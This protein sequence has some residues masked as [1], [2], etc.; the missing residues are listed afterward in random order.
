MK[1][2]RRDNDRV[3][4][5]NQVAARVRKPYSHADRRVQ[6]PGLIGAA[7]NIRLEADYYRIDLR[8]NTAL[9]RSEPDI[10]QISDEGYNPAWSPVL[11]V[12]IAQG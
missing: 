1:F 5:R 4:L 12:R 3:A 11:R 9:Q 2:T 8:A 6:L 10:K 7:V